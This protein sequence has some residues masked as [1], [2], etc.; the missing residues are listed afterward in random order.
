MKKNYLL[1][2]SVLSLLMLAGCET[3]QS[4]NPISIDGTVYNT[5]ISVDEPE[6][7]EVNENTG[8]FSITTSDGTYSNSGNIYTLSS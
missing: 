6:S 4:S 2:L 7:I 3:K 5:E 8:E 1:A